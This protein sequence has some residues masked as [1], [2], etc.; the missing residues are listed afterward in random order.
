MSKQNTLPNY[1]SIDVLLQ[2]HTVPLTAA[3]MHGLITGFICGA[4][5]DSSWKTLLHDLTNEGLAFLKRYQT[6]LKRFI[7]YL[8]TT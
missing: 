7:T 3:E 1:Q 5:R 8:R 2:Q 4:V 6:L